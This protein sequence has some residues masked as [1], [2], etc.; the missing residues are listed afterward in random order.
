M[1]CLPKTKH[2]LYNLQ[3]IQLVVQTVIEISKND[4]FILEVESC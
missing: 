3:K 2:S 1:V 4:E